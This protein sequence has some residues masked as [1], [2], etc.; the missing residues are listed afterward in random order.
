MLHAYSC[1]APGSPVIASPLLVVVPA[2]VYVEGM[3]RPML[4]V[5]LENVSAA[6]L[7][8]PLRVSVP[9]VFSDAALA[10]SN[11]PNSGFPVWLTVLIAAS[12]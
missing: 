1:V 7:E 6:E 9:P 10:L 2:A 3:V 5:P 11:V 12:R 8:V 4:S